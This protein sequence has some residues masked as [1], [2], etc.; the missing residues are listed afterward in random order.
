MYGLFFFGIYFFGKEQIK[1]NNGFFDGTKPRAV[2]LDLFWITLFLGILFTAFLGLRPFA[3]PDEARYTEIPREMLIQKDWITPRLN[4]FK[5]FEKPP[6]QYWIQATLID[7]FG[8]K[9]GF[10][11]LGIAIFGLVTAW[12]V[13]GIGR[14]FYNRFVG[15]WSALILGTSILYFILCRII[16]LD[17]PVGAWISWALFVFLM[18]N[19]ECGK[20]LWLRAFFGLFLGCA[21]LTKGL[22]GLFIPGS[23]ICIW[24]VSTR[25]WSAWRFVFHPLV[26]IVFLGVVLPWH[27]QVSYKNPEFLKFYFWY[28]HVERYLTTVHNRYQPLWFFIPVFLLGFLPWSSFFLGLPSIFPKA[29]ENWGQKFVWHICCSHKQ[30]KSFLD[31]TRQWTPLTYGQ[32]YAFLWIWI[33]FVF[34]FFSC[35]HSKL[36]PYIVP[37]F[38]PA[39]LLL[40]LVF[41]RYWEDSASGKIFGQILDSK[42]YNR[43][44]RNL[45]RARFFQVW[46]YGLILLALGIYHIYWRPLDQMGCKGQWVW[47]VAIILGLIFFSVRPWGHRWL[48]MVR[49]M[50]WSKRFKE[51]SPEKEQETKCFLQLRYWMGLLCGQ[52][53][54]LV[55]IATMDPHVQPR[56]CLR[57][58]CE[59]IERCSPSK[60]RQ[61]ISLGG[62]Y[63]DLPVYLEEPVYVVNQIGELA[64]GLATEPSN[65]MYLSKNQ[66]LGQWGKGKRMFVVLSEYAYRELKKTLNG[67]SLKHWVILHQEKML[68]VTDRFLDPGISLKK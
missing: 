13:Y 48:Q 34:C 39:S 29:V 55:W 52:S 22:I 42:E 36:V 9:E 62:Y 19:H 6:L 32:L 28:E 8:L 67:L 59:T 41:S 54:F 45:K 61:V 20:N 23:I 12:W 64:F 37:M 24:I 26:M 7:F 21:V 18:G 60:E 10:L 25:R 33:G 50:L 14:Y 51:K 43:L 31:K 30:E 47:G 4:G 57:I 66:M 68:L 49:A 15:L 3:T 11:R 65:P 1:L 44:E 2:S 46:H 27:I 38:P 16:I 53:M 17:L 5:Y 35:S 58:F 40:G 56:P 63:Q